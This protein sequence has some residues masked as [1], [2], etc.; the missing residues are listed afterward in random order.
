MSKPQPDRGLR[1]LD[2]QRDR[3][4]HAGG[5]GRSPACASC[6]SGRLS[7]RTLVPWVDLGI[8]SAFPVSTDRGP[9]AIDGVW[10]NDRGG[11][12]AGSLAGSRIPGTGSGILGRLAHP[13]PRSVRCRHA[14]FGGRAGFVPG[15]DRGTGGPGSRPTPEGDGVKRRRVDGG[16]DESERRKG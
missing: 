11:P 15:R 14:R 6:P 16:R 7:A 13:P 1:Q 9:E 8:R 4:Q 5:P 2:R 12:T 3:Q 10:G